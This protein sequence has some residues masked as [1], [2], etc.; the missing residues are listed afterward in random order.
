MWEQT[1]VKE[2]FKLNNIIYKQ[3]IFNGYYITIDGDIAQ[4]KFTNDGKLKSYFL[5]K[6]ETCNSGYKRVE[7]NGKH[8]LI[9]RLVYQ[10]WSNDTLRN[11]MVIDHIDANP[12]NNNLNNLRQ[13]S[14]WDNI[15]NGINHGNF[16]HNGNTKIEVYN[17]ETGE[18]KRYDSIKDFYRDINAPEYFFKHGGLCMLKKRKE[19]NK[20]VCRKIDEH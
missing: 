6:Q 20:Y 5:M 11:D 8:Y 15:Q 18:I 7:I 10:T 12:Q 9:H 14:Q 13:V 3:T 4:I 19:Y 16:G 17:K 2:E 1:K